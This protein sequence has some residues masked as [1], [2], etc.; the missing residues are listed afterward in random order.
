[1][2]SNPK[3]YASWRFGAWIYSLHSMGKWENLV[4]MVLLWN[5]QQNQRNF[6]NLAGPGF[7]YTQPWNLKIT[8]WTGLPKPNTR[9]IWNTRT[10]IYKRLI[11]YKRWKTLRKT[12]GK[13]R[14]IWKSKQNYINEKNRV[15][16]TRLIKQSRHN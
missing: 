8:K 2:K 15:M 12:I 7:M 5:T 1:M 6:R 10:T 13:I 14:K 9:I 16:K 4:N 3:A 11:F